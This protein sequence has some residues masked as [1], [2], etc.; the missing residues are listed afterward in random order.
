MGYA[1][2]AKEDDREDEDAVA[3]LVIL[4]EQHVRARE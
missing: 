1:Y 4:I 3:G 2:H